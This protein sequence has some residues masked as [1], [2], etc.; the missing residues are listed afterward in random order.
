MCR[1]GEGGRAR[2]S[3]TACGRKAHRYLAVVMEF[4]VCAAAGKG[5]LLRTSARAQR[6]GNGSPVCVWQRK[7]RRHWFIN[8]LGVSSPSPHPRAYINF[9]SLFIVWL[10]SAVFYHLP[11]L[12]T[13]GLNAKADLSLLIVVFLGTLAVREGGGEQLHPDRFRQ[14]HP[15]AW[16]HWK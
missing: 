9:H 11:S 6:P 14:I 2:G 3:E 8:A 4:R 15:L 1:G 13:M 16:G 5:S 10:C 7:G 12:E